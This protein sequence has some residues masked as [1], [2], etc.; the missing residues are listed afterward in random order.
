MNLYLNYFQ[1]QTDRTI[2]YGVRMAKISPQNLKFAWSGIDSDI[3]NNLVCDMPNKIMKVQEL[4]GDYI[5]KWNESEYVWYSVYRNILGSQGL[6][7]TLDNKW[8]KKK[9]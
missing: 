6:E 1:H 2:E 5:S 9:H 7:N 4:S 8:S 3:L